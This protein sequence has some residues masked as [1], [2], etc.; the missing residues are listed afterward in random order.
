[1]APRRRWLQFS[2]RGVFVLLTATCLL[3]AWKVG[4]ALKQIRAVNAIMAADGHV[5]YYG[6]PLAEQSDHMWNAINGRPLDISL[7]GSLDADLQTRLRDVRRIKTLTIRT[8]IADGDLAYLYDLDDPWE[9]HFWQAERLTEDALDRL[10][11]KFPNTTIWITTPKKHVRYK[12]D[13]RPWID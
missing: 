9:I 7:H 6:L 10:K 2:L 8:G 5:I 13:W 4:P 1:M 3:L 12:S 11:T